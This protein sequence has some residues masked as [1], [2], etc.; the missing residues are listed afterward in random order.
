MSR[1]DFYR[2]WT[3]RQFMEEVEV[4]QARVLVEQLKSHTDQGTQWIACLECFGSHGYRPASVE[5]APAGRL[6]GGLWDDTS[7]DWDD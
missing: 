2:A 7:E 4:A 1:R 5:P 3:H 6:C